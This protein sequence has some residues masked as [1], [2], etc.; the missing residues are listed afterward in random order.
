M[1]GMGSHLDSLW[2]FCLWLMAFA[3]LFACF[4]AV[5]SVTPRGTLGLVQCLAIFYS[6][7]ESFFI[8]FIVFLCWNG[9]SESQG[10][11]MGV[12]LA[13][14][15]SGTGGGSMSN[16]G[17]NMLLRRKWCRWECKRYCAGFRHP[18]EHNNVPRGLR[19]RARLAGCWLTLGWRGH[20]LTVAVGHSCM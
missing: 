1:L 7:F 8:Y 19:R 12:M 9:I 18:I 5:F 13:G 3:I 16:L 10:N 20:C 4:W 15:H 17:G 6:F 2:G 14:T 11:I